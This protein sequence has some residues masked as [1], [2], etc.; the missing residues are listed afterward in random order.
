MSESSLCILSYV[1]PSSAFSESL[2]LI[3]PPTL[4]HADYNARSQNAEVGL[5]YEITYYQVSSS[6]P[7]S[8]NGMT[9]NRDLVAYNSKNL[10]RWLEETID[11]VNAFVASI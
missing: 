9:D 6:P 8:S 4:V 1:N 3:G 2:S 7:T 5:I 10:D 11:R